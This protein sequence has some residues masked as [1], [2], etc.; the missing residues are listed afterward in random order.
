MAIRAIT[1]AAVA[2]LL[3]GPAA[4]GQV[5]TGFKV[6][7]VIGETPAAPASLDSASTFTYGGAGLSV[8]AGGFT[9]VRRIGRNRDLFWFAARKGLDLYRVAV[10]VTTGAIVVVEPA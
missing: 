5:A 10:S 8:M 7:I 6:G 3:A 9:D 4:A 1:I 2:M